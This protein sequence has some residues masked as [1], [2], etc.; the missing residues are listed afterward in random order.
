MT[1][2]W[3]IRV[4]ILAFAVAVLLSH[5][6]RAQEP[7]AGP[8]QIAAP[9]TQGTEDPATQWARLHPSVMQEYR[10]QY[11]RPDGVVNWVWYDGT[12]R[13]CVDRRA[14]YFGENVMGLVTTCS[15]DANDKRAA[16]LR[17]ERRAVDNARREQARKASEAAAEQRQLAIAEHQPEAIQKWLGALLGYRTAL[18]EDKRDDAKVE[19]AKEKKYSRIVGVLNKSAVYEAQQRIRSADEI[20]ER[21]RETAKENKVKVIGRND[22]KIDQVQE[23][24]NASYDPKLSAGITERD[25]DEVVQRARSFE[26]EG[27]DCLWILLLLRATEP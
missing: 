20:I 17:E 24:I 11:T 3:R 26:L 27:Q 16:A 9:V 14:G 13:E 22:P 21:Q 19:I 1:M 18:A 4:I 12:F 5:G 15:M 7:L 8:R 2:M 23:C 25:I 10:R 6:T